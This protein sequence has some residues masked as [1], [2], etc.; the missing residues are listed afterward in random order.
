MLH[1]HIYDI[2]SLRVNIACW[3]SEHLK[4]MSI[5]NTAVNFINIIEKKSKNLFHYKKDTFSCKNAV[6]TKNKI[7]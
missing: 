1:I 6:E 5:N 3:Y 4:K 7:K 2:R